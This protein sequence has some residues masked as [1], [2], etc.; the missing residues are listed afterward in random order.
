M[1]ELQIFNNPKF[2]QI[3]LYTEP[4]GS[5]TFCGVDAAV[6]LGYS[7][8]RDAVNR[9]CKSDGVVFHDVVDSMGRSQKTK[10]VTEGNLYRLIAGSELPG[11]DEFEHWIFDEVL[12]SIRKHGGYLTPDKIEEILSDP[13]T[14]I[15]IATDLKAERAKNAQLEAKVEQDKPKVLFA[16]A[17]ATA[18]TSI[19]I[20]ELAKL[21]KQNGVDTGQNRLFTW[22]RDNGYLIRRSGVDYNMPT[23]KSMELGLLEIKERTIADPNG[24]VRITKTTK[25]TGKGQQ[26]FIE[27]FLDKNVG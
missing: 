5:T 14:I 27:K 13:D 8:T 21:L 23:Q 4:D 20:G 25:V 16:D 17:V 19:L 6:A 24:C 11:A 7:N 2:G 10:F 18:D 1:N 3:R 26:Y 12:P 9:H 22:L 15:R